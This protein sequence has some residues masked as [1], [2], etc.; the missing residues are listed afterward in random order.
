[1]PGTNTLAYLAS[2][3]ATKE[4]S[5]QNISNWCS[6]RPKKVFESA[7]GSRCLAP[8][9]KAPSLSTKFSKCRRGQGCYVICPAGILATNSW[10]FV[11][12]GMP[13]GIFVNF[14]RPEILVLTQFW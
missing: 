13:C 8:I 10:H 1:M 3:S 5:F 9:E 14:T 2:S 6:K 12:L 7:F 4:K 11:S